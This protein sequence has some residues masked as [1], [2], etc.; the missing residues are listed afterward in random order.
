MKAIAF[1]ILALGLATPA[2]A[3]DEPAGKPKKEKK[4]CKQVERAASRMPSRICRTQAEWDGTSID[5]DQD[6]LELLNSE[7]KTG[8]GNGM[9]CSGGTSRGP[10]R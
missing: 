5:A 6:R 8:C 4:I 10:G 7:A 2:T 9:G 3:A 1:A